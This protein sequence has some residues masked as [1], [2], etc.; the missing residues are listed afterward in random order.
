[1]Q[2]RR[3]THFRCHA[4]AV[5]SL[6]LILSAVTARAHI[7]L[8]LPTPRVPGSD[9]IK[10]PQRPCGGARDPAR[11]TTLTAG[12]EVMFR[13]VETINHR[14]YYSIELDETGD[15]S[16]TV[17]S[18]ELFNRYRDYFARRNGVTLQS[19]PATITTPTDRDGVVTLLDHWGLHDSAPNNRVVMATV[20]LPDRTCETCTLRL[21]QIMAEDGR[22]YPNSAFYFHCADVRIE[23]AGGA[24]GAMGSGGAGGDGGA[25]AA[26]GAMGS[27]GDTTPAGGAAG[28]AATGGAPGGAGEPGGGAAGEAG[29]A[30]GEAGGTPDETRRRGA[31]GGCTFAQRPAPA[32]AVL[33]LLGVITLWT[34]R[35]RRR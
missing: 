7:R 32:A 11:V 22:T 33:A 14:G 34:G 30:G 4:G 2:L 28:T 29:E 19:L 26:G 27:G 5:A 1:M 12:Q 17:P 18:Q 21:T 3:R 20:R 16:F 8:E 13:W 6:T 23:A 31:S 25:G 35:T 9:N 24:G 15:D 10:W